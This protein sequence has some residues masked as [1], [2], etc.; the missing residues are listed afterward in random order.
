MLKLRSGKT[1]RS[2]KFPTMDELRKAMGN[3]AASTVYQHLQ[4]TF[5]KK[6]QTE[7]VR[8]DTDDGF[9]FH[10]SSKVYAEVCRKRAKSS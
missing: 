5:R 7:L 6:D 9:D 8:L 2:R 1:E 10:Q 3:K 4:R